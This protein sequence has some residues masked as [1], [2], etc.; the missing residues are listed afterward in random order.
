MIDDNKR[1]VP[2]GEIITVNAR[3]AGKRG[4]MILADAEL[5]CSGICYARAH[6]AFTLS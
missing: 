5:L 1:A 2:L 4:R 3:R 6:G